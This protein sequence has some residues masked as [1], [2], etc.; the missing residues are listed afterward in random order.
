MNAID[1]AVMI[2]R[3]YIVT[4]VFDH[5]R[6]ILGIGKGVQPNISEIN[7]TVVEHRKGKILTALIKLV[8]YFLFGKS[9]FD[10][11]QVL[12]AGTL[13]HKFQTLAPRSSWRVASPRESQITVNGDS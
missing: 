11:A 6:P 3:A 2:A 12:K 13:L 9:C 4:K 1:D 10:H 8:Q 7:G 5:N